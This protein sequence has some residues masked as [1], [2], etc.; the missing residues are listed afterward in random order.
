MRV[1][2]QIYWRQSRELVYLLV[3]WIVLWL[4]LMCNPSFRII[5]IAWLIFSKKVPVGYSCRYLLSMICLLSSWILCYPWS[6]LRSGPSLLRP[7]ARIDSG[8]L[9]STRPKSMKHQALNHH[10]WWRPSKTIFYLF[11]PCLSSC[12]LYSL[13]LEQGLA[14]KILLNAC[15]IYWLFCW[16]PLPKY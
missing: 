1:E 13:Y 10:H 5:H 4:Q 16:I 2:A 3:V 9:A 12:S 15:F 11:A 14:N 6:V 7:S 8:P